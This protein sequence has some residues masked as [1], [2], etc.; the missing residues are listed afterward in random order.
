MPDLDRFFKSANDDSVSGDNASCGVLFERYREYSALAKRLET[1]ETSS[2]TEM[3]SQELEALWERRS[4]LARALVDTPAPAI[5]D[6]VFKMT[7]VSSLVAEERCG[8]VLHNSAWRS[9]SGCSRSRPSA[10][11]SAWRLSPRYGVHANKFSRTR[12]GS[13]GGF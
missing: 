6:V 13:S 4:Q 2:G 3:H 8:W 10:N 7:I 12:G 11:K 1:D 5:S 9:A